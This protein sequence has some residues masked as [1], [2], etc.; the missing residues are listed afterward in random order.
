M[1]HYLPKLGSKFNAFQKIGKKW[2]LCRD[3]PCKTT[4]VRKAMVSAVDRVGNER[5]FAVVNWKF[6]KC[7]K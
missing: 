5:Q 4:D 1:L 6:E 7:V 3:A 2:I